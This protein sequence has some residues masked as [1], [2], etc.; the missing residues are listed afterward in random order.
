MKI[1]KRDV[2]IF[3]LGFICLLLIEIIY[4]WKNSLNEFKRGYE[5]EPSLTSV[6]KH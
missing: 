3:A 1:T 6:E 4:N 2:K 5:S